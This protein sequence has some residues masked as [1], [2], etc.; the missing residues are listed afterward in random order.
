MYCYVLFFLSSLSNLF[1]CPGL[2]RS[3]H[4]SSSLHFP[5]SSYFSHGAIRYPPHLA[6]DPLKDLVT[7][8]C[9]PASHSSSS[10]STTSQKFSSKMKIIKLQILFPFSTSIFI[11]QMTTEVCG[12]IIIKNFYQEFLVTSLIVKLRQPIPARCC[13]TVPAVSHLGPYRTLLPGTSTGCVAQGF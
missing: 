11:T 3:S 12:N 5:S 1:L 9:D 7:L 2:S 6:Q 4:P 10:V 13:A 8:A